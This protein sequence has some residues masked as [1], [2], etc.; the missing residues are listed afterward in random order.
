M[1]N[2]RRPNRF[3]SMSP[4][5]EVECLPGGFSDCFRRMSAQLAE[6]CFGNPELLQS[7]VVKPA[8]YLRAR[9]NW[10]RGGSAVWMLPSDV[11]P[12]LARAHKAQSLTC[13]H[14]LLRVGGHAGRLVRYPPA[15]ACLP[16]R[17]L[18]G[19]CQK[20]CAA[21]DGL[22]PGWR[23]WHGNRQ[24]LERTQ[25]MNRY[26]PDGI[27]PDNRKEFSFSLAMI[28]TASHPTVASAALQFR[29]SANYG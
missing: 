9:V 17:T 12:L 6:F 2:S 7:A 3:I 15:I 19:S 5:P 11:A 29:I 20:H 27:Q 18:R 1:T 28:A 13:T 25:Q 21:L 23:R 4:A 8:T 14:Q 24:S 16:Q 10:D 22:V 26:R